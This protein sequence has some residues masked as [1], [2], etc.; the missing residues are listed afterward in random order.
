MSHNHAGHVPYITSHTTALSTAGAGQTLAITGFGLSLA[1]TVAIPAAL[2]VE[3]A[4]S[5]TKASATSG[6]LTITLT[7]ESFTEGT[8]TSRTISISQGGVP[9][10]GPDVSAGAITVYHGWTPAVLCTGD[11]AYWWNPDSITGLSDGAAVSSFADSVQSYVLTEGT[12]SQQPTYQS[13]YTFGTKSAAAIVSED[14]DGFTENVIPLELTSGKLEITLAFVCKMNA[15]LPTVSNQV[16]NRIGYAT[17]GASSDYYKQFGVNIR[18]KQVRL[19]SPNAYVNYGGSSIILYPP[20]LAL[21]I[22]TAAGGNA[23]LQALPGLMPTALTDTY[24]PSIAP[25]N[26]SRLF[27]TASSAGPTAYGETL[28]LSRAITSSEITQ[29]Q[30]YWSDK[31][32]S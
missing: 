21:V 15:S 5:Y 13:S 18:R 32:G 4:R 14:G 27:H 25:T 6:T 29:L 31:Y 7:V 23:T 8:S 24:T 11:K 22:M 12:G 30:D 1:T 9:C 16:E 10:Q 2:G 3:T 20:R 17:S 26:A 19:I 28:V